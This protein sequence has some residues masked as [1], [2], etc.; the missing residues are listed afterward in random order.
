MTEL[1]QS[2]CLFCKL[3]QDPGVVIWENDDFAAFKD[4]HPK[5]RIHVLVVPKQHVDSLD[6]L[7]A[8][9]APEMVWA[10]QE[11]AKSL[12]VSGRYRL[13]VN[14]GREGGQEIDHLHLHLLAS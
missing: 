4:I 9:M 12:G 11:V 2:N 1:I 7:P 13:Q 3:S 5:D 14:V 6:S 8:E 10:V